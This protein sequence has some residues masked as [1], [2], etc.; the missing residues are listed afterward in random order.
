MKYRYEVVLK[1]LCGPW[2]QE[3]RDIES[4]LDEFTSEVNTW[5]DAGYKPLGGV[6]IVSDSTHGG[7]FAC[8]SLVRTVPEE[9]DD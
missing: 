9:S 1:H 4:L 5:T 8:Q 2:A 3:G 7:W 6:Q